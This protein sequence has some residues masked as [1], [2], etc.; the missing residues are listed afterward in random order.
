MKLFC[1]LDKKTIIIT[2]S[3]RKKIQEMIAYHG[4]KMNFDE[5]NLAY[6]GTGVGAQE[7]GEGIYLTFD[8]EAAYGYGGTVYTVNIP[9]ENKANYIYYDRPIP[10]DLF[11][12]IIDGIIAD[13]TR[14]YPDEYTDEQSVDDLRQELYN[15]MDPSEGRHLMYNI[16]RYIDDSIVI[17][18][19]LKN[20]GVTG[21]IYN[22][23]KVDNV[24]MFSSRDIKILDK[25]TVNENKNY[26][27]ETIKKINQC[28]NE[29]YGINDELLLVANKL[30][31]E[32]RNKI[33]KIPVE[34]TEEEGLKF[35]HLSLTLSSSNGLFNNCKKIKNNFND[36]DLVLEINNYNFK[37]NNYYNAYVKKHGN[38]DVDN[39]TIFNSHYND[40][41]FGVIYFNYISIGGKVTNK[42][43]S[44]IYHELSH[45]F[46]QLNIG[47][48][49]H[50]SV[51]MTNVN[52]NLS[53]EDNDTKNIS[54]ILYYCDDAEQDSIVNGLYGYV[55]NSEQKNLLK[56]N[57]E[58]NDFIKNDTSFKWSVEL[59]KLIEWLKNNNTDKINDIIKNDFKLKSID[60]LIKYAE[61][62]E[63]RLNQKITKCIFKIKKDLGLIEGYGIK[64]ESKFC[65]LPFER[66]VIS[67]EYFTPNELLTENIEINESLL[68][69]ATLDDIYTKYYSNIPQDEFWQIIKADPT[70]N[71][72]KS[73]K[74]GKYGKWLLNLYKQ[75][76][77]KNED[78]YK[79]TDYLSY[80][81]KYYNK[82]TE[83]DINK[84][85]DLP[86]LYN[87]IKPYKEASDNG[88]DIATS[89]SD[90]VRRIK[91]DAEKVFE[92]NQWLVVVPHT[93]E[94]SCYYGKNTQWCTAATDSYNMFNQYNNKGPLFINIRKTDGK[95]FQFHFETNSF[96]DETDTPIHTPIA[97]TIGLNANLV[98]YYIS[99]YGGKAT[100]LLTC[101]NLDL[102][103]IDIDGE[104]PYYVYN[105][106]DGY[107]YIVEV[108][109]TQI[110]RCK[111]LESDS[112]TAD[113]DISYLG[114]GNFKL[115]NYQ[116]KEYYDDEDGEYYRTG[117]FEVSEE[118]S[119]YNAKLGRTITLPENVGDIFK[120]N[121]Q[122]IHTKID[123]NKNTLIDSETLKPVFE[124]TALVQS[125]NYYL[126]S[127]GWVDDRRKLTRYDDNLVIT[128]DY[129]AYKEN[130]DSLKQLYNIKQQSYVIPPFKP[131][132]IVSKIGNDGYEY[133]TFK[134]T[135][136][137]NGGIDYCTILPDGSLTQVYQTESIHNDNDLINE[138][139]LIEA[140][141]KDIYPKYYNDIPQDIFYNIIKTD[142]TYDEQR[143]QK[144]GKYGK[145]LLNQYRQGNL[146]MNNL[147]KVRNIIDFFNRY[148]RQ[149][150]VKDINQYKNIDQVYD[151]VKNFMED[152]SQATSKSDEVR[153][154]K[155]MG[156]EKVYEDN[157]WL[158]IVPKTQEAAIYYGKG[159]KW[160]TASTSGYNYFE[161][162]NNEGRLYININKNTGDK[163]QFH[164]ESNSFMDAEDKPIKGI[165]AEEIGLS[166]GAE[167]FY[168]SLGE[169][170]E[171][172]ISSEEHTDPDEEPEEEEI[173]NQNGWQMIYNNNTGEI[174]IHSDNEN[175]DCMIFD[176]GSIE[177]MDGYPIVKPLHEFL[178]VFVIEKLQEYYNNET[179]YKM[180]LA[181]YDPTDKGYDYYP[182]GNN[183][184]VF[185]YYDDINSGVLYRVDEQTYQFAK[186]I[187]FISFDLKLKDKISRASID[188][189]I[190]LNE[191][192]E[193]LCY[194]VNTFTWAFDEPVDKFC[195]TNAVKATALKNGQGFVKIFK[196]NTVIQV[197]SYNNMP[198]NT[199]D[200]DDNANAVIIEVLN[201]G[202]KAYAVYSVAKNQYV[203]T[204]LYASACY[205]RTKNA[206]AMVSDKSERMTDSEFNLTKQGS[207]YMMDLYYKYGYIIYYNPDS[208]DQI[209]F[210]NGKSVTRKDY[211]KSEEVYDF[212]VK[213]RQQPKLTYF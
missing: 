60:F 72:Q 74:M 5:F 106:Y 58:I 167:Q 46:Q 94:A 152:P 207:D 156:A 124:T 120:F 195:F 64:K 205:M 157:D 208:S 179:F 126:Q 92:D 118:W 174:I 153:K 162:Y 105:D 18:K 143:S 70:Y 141:L 87:I 140:E 96:M 11:S 138:S 181:D 212:L 194:N 84:L 1:N 16:H 158:I 26:I 48:R 129:S 130:G 111:G 196:N 41:A 78:L 32:I 44:D 13:M 161:R 79:A 213:I 139:Y 80:F 7:F 4:S 102:D 30:G 119:I 189:L 122:Y 145:W 61:R 113:N 147:S 133:L 187:D 8:K 199:L 135:Q 20:A 159:T 163:Y 62:K 93:Q 164:F 76:K 63:K 115:H 131:Y 172:A 117:E 37:N 53:S 27:N 200:Y 146:D 127:C 31:N 49:Y 2:E 68:L 55:I 184:A 142:P 132:T 114:N 34:N 210:A 66:K 82:I 206:I 25:E 128:I 148:N 88:E 178:P 35:R 67:E 81:V 38:D 33:Q 10:S 110:T 108:K 186:V 173:L 91:E 198:I 192:D 19:I 188:N 100:I 83:K 29:E 165:I 107:Y 211:F 43:Y 17:P 51:F 204:K 21:F 54:T 125:A 75:G 6:I 116:E 50:N 166:S 71:E 86:S 209:I 85:P 59:N 23:G 134:H 190:L 56:T 42:F 197:P 171:Y 73:Q 15:I 175:E 191:Y 103:N 203:N 22:N 149:L 99:R 52:T 160:C 168:A 40:N 45:Y 183:D 109:G 201:N 150:E 90:E 97:K 136:T 155:E 182:I 154:I 202:E 3:Q 89:K 176:D 137:T 39:G 69:E 14:Q 104:E 24:I 185:K 169:N 180:V 98:Q 36:F 177:Q 28:I 151:N 65:H 123:N 12:T 112:F 121:N 170:Q 193:Q 95:K 77:L 47:E 57:N 144:M 101:N 9:D